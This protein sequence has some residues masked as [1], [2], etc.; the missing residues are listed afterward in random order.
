MKNAKNNKYPLYERDSK[1]KVLEKNVEDL[2]KKFSI[3]SDFSSST[4]TSFQQRLDSLIKATQQIGAS[5]SVNKKKSNEVVTPQKPTK[6][7]QPD[8]ETK[9]KSKDPAPKL[10]QTSR[11]NNQIQI[12]FNDSSTNFKRFYSIVRQFWE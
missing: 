1:V 2:L 9:T 4:H 5:S 12:D 3:E 7:H 6:D 11:R 8:I 10:K